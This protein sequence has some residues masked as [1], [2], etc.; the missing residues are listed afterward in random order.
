MLGNPELK[1]DLT[2]PKNRRREAMTKKPA[3]IARRKL[4]GQGEEGTVALAFRVSVRTKHSLDQAARDDK[5][6]L[7]SLVQKVL[8]DWLDENGY[9]NDK[10]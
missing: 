10:G 1:V 9:A 4:V 3:R 7:S 2:P 5:R 8:T 6:S